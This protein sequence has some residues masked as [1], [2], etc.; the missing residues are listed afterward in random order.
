LASDLG[1]VPSIANGQGY[2]Q[3]ECQLVYDIAV[4][5][6][7][8]PASVQARWTNGNCNKKICTWWAL[9]YSIV[10]SG[11][12]GTLPANLQAAWTTNDCNTVFA[13]GFKIS[14][15]NGKY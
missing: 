10:A 9:N 1:N 4:S 2:T 6:G 13:K 11:T 12:W 3:T 15:P 14:L 7:T 5:N 8:A